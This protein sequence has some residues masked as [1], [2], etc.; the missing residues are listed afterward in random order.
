MSP[1]IVV[2]AFATAS[3]LFMSVLL[4][5]RLPRRARWFAVVPAGMAAV[6][7]M[8][9]VLNVL[10]TRGGGAVARLVAANP[11]DVR[12]IRLEPAQPPGPPSLVTST[13]RVIER[14]SI[15]EV[16][17]ALRV[18]TEYA[19][20]HP[21]GSWSVVLG[22]EDAHGVAYAI[23]EQTARQGVLLDVWS[24]RTGGTL[25][26]QLRCDALGPVLARLARVPAAAPASAR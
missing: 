21:R 15:A 2:G 17:T 20:D 25:L 18:S 5:V 24:G 7:G 6:A 9:T 3:A 19:P 12:A 1:Q 8:W 23:V 13:V 10:A 16:L 14:T 26:G 11:A 22:I 4:V